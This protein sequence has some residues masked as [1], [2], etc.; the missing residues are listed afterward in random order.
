M[1]I[2]SLLALMALPLALTAQEHGNRP[3]SPVFEP[4]SKGLALTGGDI[5]LF[6]DKGAETALI[7]ANRVGS[8]A[9]AFS[10]G[11]NLIASEGSDGRLYLFKRGKSEMPASAALKHAAVNG[12]SRLSFSPD[13]K[14]I[15]VDHGDRLQ[16]FH[17]AAI[18]E[19][20]DLSAAGLISL[21]PRNRNGKGSFAVFSADWSRVLVAG[22]ITKIKLGKDVSGEAEEP[23]LNDAKIISQALAAD[24]SK[25]VFLHNGGRD[26]SVYDTATRKLLAYRG[27]RSPIGDLC[28]D[29]ALKTVFTSDEAWNWS[30]DSSRPITGPKGRVPG[31]LEL[32]PDGKIL[33]DGP[34]LF[35]A[36]TLTV[37]N[38]LRLPRQIAADAW[39]D[40]NQ[41]VVLQSTGANGRYDV[42]SV[43]LDSGN[44]AVPLRGRPHPRLLDGSIACSPDGSWGINSVGRIVDRKSRS[45]SAPTLN[46]AYAQ[47]LAADCGNDGRLAL[48][49]NN[50]LH[51]S[52]DIRKSREAPISIA[53]PAKAAT[54]AHVLVSPDSRWAAVTWSV[55]EASWLLIADL[56][57]GKLLNTPAAFAG[58]GSLAFAG[59]GRLLVAA[60]RKIMSW[61]IGPV[62]ATAKTPA[63]EL[64]ASHDTAADYP[65]ESGEV[66]SIT[67]VGRELLVINR[68]GF[69]D[70]INLQRSNPVKRFWLDNSELKSR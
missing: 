16:F 4:G 60:G 25:A 34:V 67:P 18:K 66:L 6:D 9:I 70:L 14:F 48:V 69:I 17:V 20:Y 32:S 56:K 33:A 43:D 51:Y 57:T 44:I 55:A 1:R 5:L 38:D 39:I 50:A 46:L 2:A 26:I 23:V 24:G 29:A 68:N 7:N 36:A 59:D 41:L 45:L 12:K 61:K 22:Q 13:G 65:L 42:Q 15:A 30:D 21:D 52:P 27:L 40:K 49:T 37:K 8:L 3:T 10:P 58:T 53:I 64:A 54:S 62:A 35:D 19:G 63:I 31:N 47:G 28:A 11:G